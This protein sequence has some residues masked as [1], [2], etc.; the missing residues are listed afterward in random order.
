MDSYLERLRRELEDA[1]A[2]SSAD[3]LTQA[4]L[5]KWNAVQILEHLLLTYKGTNR[6]L[7]KCVELG[8]PQGTRSTLKDRV[9]TL[10]VVNL[11]YMP[12]GRKSPERAMPRGMEPGEVRREIAGEMQRMIAGLDECERKFGARAK[13]MDHPFLGP[14]TAAEWRK[15]HWVHGRHHARQIRERIG[16]A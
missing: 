12:G 16:K 14:L 2:G 1:T 3:S 6:A 10:L 9:A 7:A 8:V 13:I 11:G 15:F 4:P 5:G